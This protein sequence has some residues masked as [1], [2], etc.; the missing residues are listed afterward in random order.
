MNAFKKWGQSTLAQETRANPLTP[1]LAI[2]A[3]FGLDLV[4]RNAKRSGL[5]TRQFAEGHRID[6]ARGVA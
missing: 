1:I 5:S 2:L 6:K 3:E 4:Q